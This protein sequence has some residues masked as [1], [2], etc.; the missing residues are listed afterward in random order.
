MQNENPIPETL[1]IVAARIG[2][3]YADCIVAPADALIVETHRRVFGPASKAECER[4]RD[5]NGV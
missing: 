1:Y 4:W 2:S 3:D 5:Q